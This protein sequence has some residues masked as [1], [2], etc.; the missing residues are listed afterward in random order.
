MPKVSIGSA[1]AESFRYL[2]PA[3]QRV[4]GILLLLAWVTAA[5]RAM[6]LTRPEW[7]LVG[8]LGPIFTVA[9]STMASGALFRLGIEAEHPGDRNFAAGP[10]GFQWGALEWRVLGANLLVGVLIGVIIVAV[11]I[12]WAIGI[13]VTVA[14][15]NP[16]DLQAIQSDSQAEKLAA[17]GRIMLGPGGVVSAVILIPATAG[18]IYLFARLSLFTLSAADTASFDLGRAWRLTRG[19]LW[20]LIL[21]GLVIYV[22]LTA[23]GFVVGLVAGLFSALGGQG[24][25]GGRLW[26]GIAGQA[27]GASISAPLFAGLQLYVYRQQ[28][29]DGGV[30]A[31]FT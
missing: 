11:V 18:L 31:T 20:A 26:G 12:V 30:A 8:V 9:V 14:G 28:R 3:W 25:T 10:A 21:A 1:I 13:G 27:I 22:A 15:G 5:I 6:E 19:A 24:I 7:K 4:W 16:A 23:F 29:G 17:L 2:Q